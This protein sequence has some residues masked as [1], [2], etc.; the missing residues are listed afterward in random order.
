MTSGAMSLRVQIQRLA[1]E[2][3]ALEPRHEAVVRRAVAAELGS[4]LAS[5]PLPRRL[6]TGGSTPGLPGGPLQIGAWKDPAD[7][8]RRVAAALHE[9][10]DR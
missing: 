10:L 4:L 7:L 2:G 6:A 8:G 1:L 5:R 9:S 3:F